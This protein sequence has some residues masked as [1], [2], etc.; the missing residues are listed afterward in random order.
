MSTSDR[1]ARIVSE[2][3]GVEVPSPRTDIIESGLIDS[4]SLVTL[5]VAIEQDLMIV[6]PLDAVAIDDIRSVER[7]ADLVDRLAVND[8][9]LPKA[10]AG[11]A[12]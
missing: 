1:I 4:L 2:T 9:P 11:Q 10:Q 3:L 5:L 12:P 7:L 6:I 8:S